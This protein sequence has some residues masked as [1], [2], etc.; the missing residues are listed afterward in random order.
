V[1]TFFVLR[2]VVDPKIS[3]VLSSSLVLIH[4]FLHHG[5]LADAFV[6]ALFRVFDQTSIIPSI[7]VPFPL[8]HALSLTHAHTRTH[9]HTRTH[10]H[11]HLHPLT[12]RGQ[13]AL[14]ISLHGVRNECTR[15]LVRAG[16]DS[17]ESG[18]SKTAAATAAVISVRIWEL[19][20][21]ICAPGFL[22][23]I[24]EDLHRKT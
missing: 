4:Q 14:I 13:T 23:A 2:F 3:V 19:E 12:Q 17:H 8:S 16:H 20:R 18:E 24:A 1:I 10:T 6:C 5:F 21:P 7:L 11:T 22:R 15:L 9:I